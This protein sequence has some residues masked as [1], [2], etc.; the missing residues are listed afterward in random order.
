MLSRLP[1]YS[2]FD[3]YGKVTFTSER[4]DQVVVNGFPFW[5]T[6]K[7]CNRDRFVTANGHAT[8]PWIPTKFP[9][10]DPRPYVALMHRNVVTVS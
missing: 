9:G 3:D 1:I 2:L 4:S 8:P 10:S 7:R 6:E 5:R